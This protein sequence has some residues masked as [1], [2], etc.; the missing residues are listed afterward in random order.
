M[1]ISIFPSEYLTGKKVVKM[2]FWIF[3]IL[4]ALSFVFAVATDRFSNKHGY[5]EKDTAFI[6]FV[7]FNDYE[8][9]TTCCV[10]GII[11]GIVVLC[12][13]IPIIASNVS[14]E[15]ERAAN[16]QRYKA[17]IY[18]AQTEDIRD[19]F[20]IVNKEYI[21]EVQAWN[22]NLARYQEKSNSFW[23][24]IFYPERRIEDVEIVNLESIQMKR[25]SE[26]EMSR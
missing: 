8:I 2:I 7:C 17:L 19:E 25:K 3:V 15:G 24:G 21:D 4:V 5:S 13:L 23:I 11:S 22:E 26:K 16:E 20:G 18:K 10:V 6:K 9:K 14:A 1:G 12:M